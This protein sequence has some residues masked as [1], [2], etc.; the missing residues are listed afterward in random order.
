MNV[1]GDLVSLKFHGSCKTNHNA[2]DFEN[3]KFPKASKISVATN[4]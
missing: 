4:K 2:N 1:I 3:Y